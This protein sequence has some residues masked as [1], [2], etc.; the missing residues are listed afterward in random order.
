MKAEMKTEGKKGRAR[1]RLKPR[2]NCGL[3]EF[4]KRVERKCEVQL[5]LGG[6]FFL[7]LAC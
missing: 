7:G 3:V 2:E 5:G 1:E 4:I 6:C